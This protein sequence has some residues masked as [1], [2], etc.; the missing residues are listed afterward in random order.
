MLDGGNELCV[1]L[2]ACNAFRQP[3]R[4][5]VVAASFEQMLTAREQMSHTLT[6]HVMLSTDCCTC[7][8]RL[9]V[10]P[11]HSAGWYCNSL[12]SSVASL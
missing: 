12:P 2:A 5:A 1:E 7:T 11:S 3:R 8:P 10:S 4:D 9:E 6:M